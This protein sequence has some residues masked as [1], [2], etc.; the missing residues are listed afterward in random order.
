MQIT[1]TVKP[2]LALN[3]S[4][5]RGYGSEVFDLLEISSGKPERA[6]HSTQH[7]RPEM[8]EGGSRHNDLPGT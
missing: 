6:T 1:S 4:R 2:V 7:S 8:G 5:Y 3:V